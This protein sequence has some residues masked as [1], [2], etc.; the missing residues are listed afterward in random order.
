MEWL[1]NLSLGRLQLVYDT[2]HILG[3]LQKENQKTRDK[4]QQIVAQNYSTAYSAQF[5]I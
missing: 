5:L 1:F 2:T 4:P 3:V